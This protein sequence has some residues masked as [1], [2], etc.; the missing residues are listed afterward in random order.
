MAS[1]DTPIGQINGKWSVLFRALLAANAFIVPALVGWGTWVT[2]MLFT[3]HT[4]M[5]LNTLDRFTSAMFIEVQD[6]LSRKNPDMEWL[7][8]AEIRRIQNNN[9]PYIKP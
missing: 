8:A 4:N 2:V 3:M 9:P 6:E 5:Q 7:K 1:S